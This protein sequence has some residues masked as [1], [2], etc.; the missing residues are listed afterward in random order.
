M[1]FINNAFNLVR[2]F[3]QHKLLLKVLDDE[4][5]LHIR[6]RYQVLVIDN[7]NVN[8]WIETVCLNAAVLIK[9]KK[10]T[11]KNNFIIRIRYTI[12]RQQ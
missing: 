2:N 5:K 10:K 12:E 6:W 1:H 8:D 9:K 3:L 7:N 4:Q 11:N